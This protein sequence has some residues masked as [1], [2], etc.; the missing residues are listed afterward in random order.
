MKAKP[1]NRGKRAAALLLLALLM[2]AP[3]GAL[4]YDAETMGTWL[5]LFCEALAA[6]TPVND[7]QE[8][9]D[10]ARP[11][12]YLLEYDFGTVLSRVPGSPGAADIVEI[13]VTTDAVTDCRGAR[14]GMPLSAAADG[15][16]P[17]EGEGTL[18]VLGTQ[19][20]GL[21]WSWAYVGDAGVYG[22]EHISYGGE[23]L[24]MREYTLTYVIGEDG[25]IESIRARVAEATEAQAEAGMRTAE[26]IAA[27]QGG[28][29]LAAKNGE[30]AL[31][32]DDLCVQGGARLL[33]PVADFVAALGEPIEIQALPG[34]TG[35]LLLYE[36]VA[37]T[38]AFDEATGEELVT[39][40]SVSGTGVTGPRGL[41]VGQSVQEA[42]SLFRC[43]ADV[44]ARGGTLYLE[45]EAAGEP[46]YGE[47]A[48]TPDGAAL[49]YACQTPRGTA[50]LEAGISDGAVAYWRMSLGKEADAG[51][52]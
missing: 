49:R 22:V 9:Y 12:E 5:G 38:L 26:E 29:A 1:A 7:P 43:D 10:P 17:E 27:R 35:R 18:R 21:G 4:A 42:A 46:P 14:V 13:D 34:G 37:L 11:G 31:A 32:A 40:V 48:V 39:G 45:G 52:E 19:D 36:G 24:D 33:S 44:T 6:M 3:A 23:G 47:L 20:A 15:T 16:I 2:L 30:T 41:A 50:T 28:E 25:M 8:T 51:D